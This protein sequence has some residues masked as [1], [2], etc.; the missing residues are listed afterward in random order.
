MSTSIQHRRAAPVLA[1]IWTLNFPNNV[2]LFYNP[3]IEAPE[4]YHGP[5]A[6]AIKKLFH[7]LTVRDARVF[8]EIRAADIED[9]FTQVTGSRPVIL[10]FNVVEAE[11]MEYTATGLIPGDHICCC[12]CGYVDLK[13]SGKRYLFTL[14]YYSIPPVEHH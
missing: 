8:C 7:F 3:V 11:A 1:P 13:G 5:L 6:I 14:L 10:T 9:F 2:N 4:K 12:I